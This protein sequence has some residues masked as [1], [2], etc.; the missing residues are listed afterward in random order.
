MPEKFKKLFEQKIDSK[1][2]YLFELKPGLYDIFVFNFTK[3]ISWIRRLFLRKKNISNVLQ[4]NWIKLTHNNL[5]ITDV[6]LHHLFVFNGMQNMSDSINIDGN[7]INISV[8]LQLDKF[9]T[10]ARD[11]TSFRL[12]INN[13]MLKNFN[14]IVY[15]SISKTRRF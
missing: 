8:V 1:T 10:T 3:N 7:Q 5:T 6:E 13:E 14:L 9:K 11:Q 2:L 12:E 4:N 15:S